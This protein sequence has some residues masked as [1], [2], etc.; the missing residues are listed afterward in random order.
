M[1][2]DQLIPGTTLRIKELVY[3]H[4]VNKHHGEGGEITNVYNVLDEKTGEIGF[5]RHLYMWRKREVSGEVF[6]TSNIKLFKDNHPEADWYCCI[7]G[8]E[9]GD[10]FGEEPDCH[11][12]LSYTEKDGEWGIRPV[13]VV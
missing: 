5:F 12:K 2:I 11:E 7:P 3:H 10:N 8:F 6:S 13:E 1:K 4:V 9:V